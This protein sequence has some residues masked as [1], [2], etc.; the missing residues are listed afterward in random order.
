[1]SS[2]I[3]KEMP[4]KH[5]PPFEPFDNSKE[6][7]LMMSEWMQSECDFLGLQILRKM[8]DFI[9]QAMMPEIKDKLDDLARQED[10]DQRYA[11][12]HEKMEGIAFDSHRER[13]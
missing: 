4:T 13:V 8:R 7:M 2:R 9:I 5:L 11:G 10:I 6:I 12:L 1:M 3:I